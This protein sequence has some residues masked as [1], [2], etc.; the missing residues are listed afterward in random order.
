MTEEDQY[1][2]D[3][4]HEQHVHDV[5]N[6]I[7]LYR[8]TGD[9]RFFWRAFLLLHESG[10]D[11]PKDF[12]DKLAKF[13]NK[14]LH[15]KTPN[16]IAFALELVG[17]EKK[18][19]GPKHSQAYYRRW[20]LASEVQIVQRQYRI[21]LSE[22]IAAVARNNCLSIAKVKGDYHKIFSAPQTKALE[23]AK[24]KQ[25]GSLAEAISLWRPVT[26]S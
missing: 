2:A 12:M 18:H 7:T 14:L 3:L 13:A 5:N 21:K 19:I 15:A 11:V 10:K 25:V 17:D 16:E 6:E 9:A 24:E 20:R 1:F 26:E 8:Q 22:A 23:K 4:D